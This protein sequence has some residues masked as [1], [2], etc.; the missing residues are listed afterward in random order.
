MGEVRVNGH[1]VYLGNVDDQTTGRVHLFVAVGALEMLG[2]L[3]LDQYFFIFKVAIAV[4][5]VVQVRDEGVP[6]PGAILL[7]WCFPLFL[8]HFLKDF[9]SKQRGGCVARHKVGRL[10]FL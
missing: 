1:F 6:A 10:D 3:V 5:R 4:P 2:F 7:L 8:G 9:Y